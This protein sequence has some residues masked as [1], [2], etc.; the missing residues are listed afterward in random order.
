MKD[1]NEELKSKIGLMKSQAKE[2]KELKKMIEAY[3]TKEKKMDKNIIPLQI[4][5]GGLEQSSGSID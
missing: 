2:L 3:E 1:E 5:I 4:A